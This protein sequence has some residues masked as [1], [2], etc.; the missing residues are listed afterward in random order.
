MRSKKT[1][2]PLACASFFAR[3]RK[4]GSTITVKEQVH[5]L[6]PETQQLASI[7]A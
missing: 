7:L 2:F 3:A 1:C 4:G 6:K 5:F